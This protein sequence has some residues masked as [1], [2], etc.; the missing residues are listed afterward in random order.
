MRGPVWPLPS[1]GT[2][3]SCLHETLAGA[4]DC[5]TPRRPFLHLCRCL[6]AGRLPQCA[7]NGFGMQVGNAGNEGQRDRRAARQVRGFANRSAQ[8]ECRLG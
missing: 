7:V 8:A 1:S 2:A 5:E 6:H 4:T 3:R